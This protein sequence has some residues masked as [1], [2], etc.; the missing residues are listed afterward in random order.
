MSEAAPTT[1]S[2]V[3]RLSMKWRAAVDRAVAPLGLTHAQF[4]VLAS[5]YGLSRRGTRPSQRELADFTGLEPVYIS[6]LARAL[7]SSG[8]I[9]RTDDPHDPRAVELTLTDHGIEIAVHA[10]AAVR[11]LHDELLEPI[12]GLDSARNR[13]LVATL[14]ALL[15]EHP[16]GESSP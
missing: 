13:E 3:W 16:Q 12:G 2:L 5:L 11:A 8:M 4:V 6:R 9:N 10:V 1:G 14:Q 7:E 15:R